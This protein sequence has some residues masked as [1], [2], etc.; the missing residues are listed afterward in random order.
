MEK[1]ARQVSAK[2]EKL[3]EC[4][5]RAAPGGALETLTILNFS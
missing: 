5:K 1:Q 3:F 2:T 4:G